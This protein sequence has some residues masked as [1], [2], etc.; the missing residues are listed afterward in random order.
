MGGSSSEF[1]EDGILLAAVV[2]SGDTATRLGSC[3]RLRKSTWLQSWCPSLL[4]HCRKANSC[5]KVKLAE[6]KHLGPEVWD[7][8]GARDPLGA[9]R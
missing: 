3:T 1:G 2:P 4:M 7:A 8:R 6:L 5:G 9:Y